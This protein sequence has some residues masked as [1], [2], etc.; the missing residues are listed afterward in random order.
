MR[1]R[2]LILGALLL[3]AALSLPAKAQAL[4]GKVKLTGDSCLIVLL[5]PAYQ[6]R[7]IGAELRSFGAGT[8]RQGDSLSG[9]ERSWGPQTWRL[10]RYGGSTEI[11]VYVDKFDMTAAKAL[12]YFAEND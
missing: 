12:D 11:Q 5:E 6:E 2:A 9:I 4:E 10:D 1:H 8:L 7:Y 3:S